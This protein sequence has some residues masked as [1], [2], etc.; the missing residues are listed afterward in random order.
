M[1]KITK[2]EEKELEIREK[3]SNLFVKHLSTSRRHKK[4]RLESWRRVDDMLANKKIDFG[5]SYVHVPLGKAHGFLNTWLSKIDNPLTFKYQK[6]EIADKR[7]SDIANAIKETDQNSGRWNW[8]DLMGKTQ[9]GS[10]G[11]AIYFYTARSP[12]GK[13]E[14]ELSMIDVLRYHIDPR[15]GGED[16]EKAR[17]HGWGN[18]ELTREELEAGRDSKE[19]IKETVDLLLSAEGNTHQKNEEDR[20]EDYRYASINGTAKNTES[21]DEDVF[22][23]Y[24]WFET[25]NNQRYTM[26]ITESGDVIQ[27]KKLEEEWASGLWPIW[28][29]APNT[30]PTEFWS[31]GEIEYQMYVFLAQEASIS[32]AL[33][34]NDRINNPQKAYNIERIKNISQLKYRRD[35]HIEVEGDDDVNRAIKEMPV[36]SI[37]TPIVIYDKLDM[38]QASAT[39]ITAGVKG[40]AE[41]DKVAIY[42]GNMQQVGDIFGLLNK[43]Y[44]EGY[45]KF[46]KLHLAGIEEHL[47]RMMAVEMIGP[48]GLYL[49]KVSKK[50]IKTKAGFNI[51][52]E[53]SN[54]ESQ[55]NNVDKKNKI[56]FL[57]GYKGDQNVNQKVLFEYGADTAGYTDEEIKRLLDTSD[58]ATSTIIA[59]AHEVFQKLLL[60]KTVKEYSGANF[61]FLNELNKLYYDNKD[62]IDVQTA[63]VIEQ[64][65]E[66][67]MPIVEQN[68]ARN[69][70]NKLSEQGAIDP[71]GGGRGTLKPLGENLEDPNAQDG[72]LDITNN[73]EQPLLPSNK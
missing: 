44:A 25:I 1:A 22:R 21:Y 8:K 55:S 67:H 28:S 68:M 49:E 40:M 42:E 51:L 13:Y 6:K 15:A 58:Y 47:T 7:K 33:E 73:Q 50:D 32:Q 4:P 16:M 69:L 23:F 18:V 53:S 52:I 59:D 36:P 9:A 45:H 60:R 5:G 71:T 20:F 3:L 2:K 39:G 62:E 70:M 56:S 31:L 29:W 11:R 54:A 37:N 24:R 65:I 12:K 19:F 27:Y 41:E 35:V 46:A 57:S 10:Y 63:M 64:F 61:V 66:A 48:D 43:S 14:N 72:A 38:V 34:N 26:L 30:S 17:W